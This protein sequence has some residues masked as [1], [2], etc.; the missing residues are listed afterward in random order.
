MNKA[1]LDIKTLLCIVFIVTV[2]LM[3][4]CNILTWN[5][6]GIMS[7]AGSLSQMLELYDIDFAFISEHKLRHE[8]SVFCRSI[9]SNYDAYVTCDAS[10]NPQS[11]CGK[12]GTCIMFK[13]NCSFSL[14]HIDN[15]P[16]D[17]VTGI[18]ILTDSDCIHA[19]S[20][21]MPPVNYTISDYIDTL[22]II[23]GLYES[24]SISGSV[25]LCGDFNATLVNTYDSSLCSARD[26]CFS[27]F[28]RSSDVHVVIPSGVKYTFRP[29]LKTIDYV[30]VD[31]ASFHSVQSSVAIDTDLC[32]VSDHVP[33]IT[34]LNIALIK[35]EQMFKPYIVWK[36]CTNDQKLNYRSK[37]TDNLEKLQTNIGVTDSLS[38]SNIDNIADCVIESLHIAASQ[39]F[40]ISKPNKHSKPYWTNE[41]KVA[42]SIQR[43]KRNTWIS[44]GRPRGNGFQAYK[45]YKT[46]KANFRRCQN[47]AK[48][49]VDQQF[50]NSLNEAAEC[51]LRLFWRLLDRQKQRKSSKLVTQII[52]DGVQLNNPDEI[53]NAFRK[54]YANLFIPIKNSN[55][56]DVFKAEIVNTSNQIGRASCRERV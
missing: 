14:K 34:T 31:E 28:V 52:D 21:Y 27:N 1:R 36:K 15:I 47:R 18:T 24:Y 8:H 42:H 12:A 37:L 2:T 43:M 20:V 39:S 56:D 29:T 51:D 10:D 22:D 19:F 32:C 16:S 9:H 50:C 40:T 5:V 54:H 13:R 44:E 33:I 38:K 4:K 49:A 11:R 41:V 48:Y 26:K 17:R 35:H 46:A 3:S 53:S 6:R 30:L 7:S 25:I 23:Q 55:Y 45:D